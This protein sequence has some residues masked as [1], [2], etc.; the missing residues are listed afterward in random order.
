MTQNNNA[1]NSTDSE[2][3]AISDRI[4]QKLLALETE[5]RELKKR[6]TAAEDKPESVQID[7]DLKTLNKIKAKLLKSQ[8]IAW[9]AHKLGTEGVIETHEA[10]YKKLGLALIVL[11]AVG[12]IVLAFYILK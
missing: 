4:D 2:V 8:K 9:Q 1:P 7:K 6:R 5:L 3:Q 11:S 10:P 12:F